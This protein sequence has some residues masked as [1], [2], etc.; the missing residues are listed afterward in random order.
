M[1]T[2]VL[3]QQEQLSA[4]TGIQS[5]ITCHWQCFSRL[6][7]GLWQA[8]LSQITPPPLNSGKGTDQGLL[9]TGQMNEVPGLSVKGMCTSVM[10]VPWQS[11]NQPWLVPFVSAGIGYASVSL[12]LQSNFTL[13]SE[14]ERHLGASLPF[15]RPLPPHGRIWECWER[16]EG[17]AI[18]ANQA[19]RHRPAAGSPQQAG[20]TDTFQYFSSITALPRFWIYQ[21]PQ[22]LT[23][24]ILG[25]FLTVSGSNQV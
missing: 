1:L 18:A 9:P 3:I 10:L 7:F 24:W 5:S 23:Y 20:R 19:A 8:V 15:H 17:R 14:R 25:H 11:E 22:P 6:N 21:H 4:S 13:S 16:R 12:P 2:S